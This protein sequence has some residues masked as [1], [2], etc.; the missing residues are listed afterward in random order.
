MQK[1]EVE[2]TTELNARHFYFP[3]I[4]MSKDV[5]N[6]PIVDYFHMNSLEFAPV[7]D[8]ARAHI[9]KLKYLEIEPTEWRDS[10]S[11]PVMFIAVT[12]NYIALAKWLVEEGVPLENDRCVSAF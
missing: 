3:L 7:S 6:M 1:P 9:A 12:H 10:F 8:A 11:R 4:N 2:L 5:G